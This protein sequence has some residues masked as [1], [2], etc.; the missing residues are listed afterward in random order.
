[1]VANSTTALTGGTQYPDSGGS[2]HVIGDSQN[3]Q[4][5]SNFE[6]PGQTFIGNGQGLAINLYG[7]SYL[8][9]VCNPNINLALH[10][11]LH[12]PSITKN[13]ISFSHFCHDYLV[14]FEFHAKHCFVISQANN[15]VLVQGLV[16]LDGLYL[17]LILKLQCQRNHAL[18][19][20]SPSS[21]SFV[22]IVVSSCNKP[23]LCMQDQDILTL[24]Y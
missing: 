8:T 11:L 2:S 15:K 13:L 12:V 5:L 22:N 6:G 16:G 23:S 7:S 4:Q 10:N 21:V 24:M 3:I 14:F 19:G 17:F 9:F 20:F 18:S 1:M